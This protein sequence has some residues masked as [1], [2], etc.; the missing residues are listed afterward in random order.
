[1]DAHEFSEDAFHDFILKDLEQCFPQSP[2]PSPKR[3][4]IYLPSRATPADDASP[5]LDMGND[6]WNN[7]GLDSTLSLYSRSS[8]S[9]SLYSSLAQGRAYEMACSSYDEPSQVVSDEGSLSFGTCPEPSRESLS[10]ERLVKFKYRQSSQDALMDAR[11]E[12]IG[13]L[14]LNEIQ[15][16]RSF[17][18]SRPGC[19]DKLPDLRSLT[20]HLHIHNMTDGYDSDDTHSSGC[21]LSVPGHHS[22]PGV[23]S[24]NGFRQ[25]ISRMVRRRR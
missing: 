5:S 15:G 23:L 18:C 22:S 19:K 12:A 6:D 8:A 20:C 13:V 4:A 3:Y 21:Y 25:I 16:G 10:A 11:Q 1:M 17:V 7:G 14:K 2:V 9:S 24:A